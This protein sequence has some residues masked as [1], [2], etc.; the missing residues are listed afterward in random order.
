[1]LVVAG[2]DG[3]GAEIE[4]E[5]IGIDGDCDAFP[6]LLLVGVTLVGVNG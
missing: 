3:A 4:V 6:L 2:M 5:L 1:M